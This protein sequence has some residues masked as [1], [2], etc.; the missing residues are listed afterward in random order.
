GGGGGDRASDRRP[1]SGAGGMK[2]LLA[3]AA[4]LLASAA[5][6]AASAQGTVDK[7]RR[8]DCVGFRVNQPN[9]FSDTQAYTGQTRDLVGSCYLITD[10]DA[11]MLWHTGLPAALRGA[12][13]DPTQPIGG[14]LDRTIVEQLAQI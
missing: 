14:R 11:Y 9:L 8:L 13:P 6:Q 3:I 1:R 10:G 7:L 5:A 2:L 4:A 12:K